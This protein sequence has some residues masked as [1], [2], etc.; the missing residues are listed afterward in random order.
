MILHARFEG[1]HA[2][3]IHSP[4]LTRSLMLDERLA[5]S[6]HCII[7]ITFSIALYRC[8]FFHKFSSL[9][10]SDHV[11]NNIFH[12]WCMKLSIRQVFIHPQWTPIE[13]IMPVLLQCFQS[14]FQ[15]ARHSIFLP[16]L[17]VRVFKSIDLGCVG[18]VTWWSFWFSTYSSFNMSDQVLKIDENSYVCF[19]GSVTLMHGFAIPLDMTS[20]LL[21]YI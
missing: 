2:A 1:V 10:R 5:Q 8:L 20:L 7:I 18:T 16:Y 19:W 14:W 6:S 12:A 4:S 9:S 11:E 3:L 13:W 15:T 21:I 17:L